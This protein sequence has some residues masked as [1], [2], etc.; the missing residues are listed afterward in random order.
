MKSDELRSL[1]NDLRAVALCLT[2][3]GAPETKVAA[4]GVILRVVEVLDQ[5]ARRQ[6]RPWWRRLWT[7]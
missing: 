1:A 5:E 7:R 2:G 3:P 6:R 4:P